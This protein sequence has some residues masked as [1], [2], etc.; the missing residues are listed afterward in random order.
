M[1]AESREAIFQAIAH[2]LLLK[3]IAKP[4]EIAEAY[5]FL[6]KNTFTTG[7]VIQIEGSAILSRSCASFYPKHRRTR[8]N[9]ALCGDFQFL[10]ASSLRVSPGK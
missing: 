7:S 4:E 10:M 5:L 6:A 9:S 8:P 2:S 1:A 3:H